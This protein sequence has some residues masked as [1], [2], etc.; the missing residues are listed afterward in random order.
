MPD[1]YGDVVEPP[2]P[3]PDELWFASEQ[4]RTKDWAR[5]NCVL[6]N[7]DGYRGTVVCDHNPNQ[8]EVNRRGSARCRAEL[9]RIKARRQ[10]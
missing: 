1:R 6:C 2:E 5:D 10:G 3:I 7:D 8:P 9:E 4:K